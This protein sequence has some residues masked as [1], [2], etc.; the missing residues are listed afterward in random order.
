MQKK[1][2]RA[3]LDLPI[4]VLT[5]PIGTEENNVDILRQRI[6]GTTVQA[7]SDKKLHKACADP[8]IG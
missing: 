6:F 3:L 4:L 1:G 5:H 2:Q 7:I 8:E